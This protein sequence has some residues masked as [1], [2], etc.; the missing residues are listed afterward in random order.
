MGA[1]GNDDAF[2]PQ[3]GSWFDFTLQFEQ[4]ALGLLPT[5]LLVAAAP[6]F[7]YICTNRPAYARAGI[8][9]WL[10]LVCLQLPTQ[11]VTILIL[12]TQAATLNL[13]VLEIISLVLYRNTPALKSDIA[14]AAASMSCVAS[15]TIVVLVV[16]EHRFTLR[17]TSLLSLYILLSLFLDVVKSRSYFLRHGLSV[18]GGLS[19]AAA[20]AKAILIGVQEVPKTALLIDKELR[21]TASKEATSG[22]WSRSVF[23]WLNSI[24]LVGFRQTLCIGDLEPLDP[25]LSAGPLLSRFIPK[26]DKGTV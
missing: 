11:L 1:T 14:L 19:A 5:G 22:F 23:V 21:Y 25:P 18:L 4:S 26:W 13:F 6:L 2:G 12:V 7:L 16:A 15:F 20:A 24:F 3:Y 9:L 8:T 17:P 10:K